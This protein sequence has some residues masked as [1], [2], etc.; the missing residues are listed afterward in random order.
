MHLGVCCASAYKI[1]KNHRLGDFLPCKLRKEPDNRGFYSFFNEKTIKTYKRDRLL[2]PLSL[3]VCRRGVL[4]TAAFLSVLF[5]FFNPSPLSAQAGGASQEG[6]APAD[7]PAGSVLAGEETIVIGEA[8]PSVPGGGTSSIL[9]VL[10]MV[11]VLALAALAIYGMVFFIKRMSRS[12]EARDPNLKV[13][14]RVPLGN[15]TFAAVISVGS[16]AW[17]VGG[18]DTGVSLIA[19]IDEA[20]ALETMLLDDA[21]KTAEAGNAR[22]PD[23]RS[24]LKRL[25]G[26]ENQA[27]NHAESLRKQRDRLKGL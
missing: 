22:F 15:G 18:G 4:I 7:N 10:R 19:E 20:E 8:P 11:L 27:A 17:L 14:A 21:R 24:L 5:L 26:G 3:L 25:G 9:V 16:R 6:T 23:F 12:P 13:L 1:L 2:S